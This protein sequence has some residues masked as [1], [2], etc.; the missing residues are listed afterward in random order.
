MQAKDEKRTNEGHFQCVCF[1]SFFFFTRL[2]LLV[3]SRCLCALSNGTQTLSACCYAFAPVCDSDLHQVD[4]SF[5]FAL[6]FLLFFFCAF[7]RFGILV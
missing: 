2:I 4:I 5:N 6:L 7:A 1:S 3:G